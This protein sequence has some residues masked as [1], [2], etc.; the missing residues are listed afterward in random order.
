MGWKPTWLTGF[1]AR[2]APGFSASTVR[3]NLA[4]AESPSTNNH[5]KSATPSLLAR[6]CYHQS[7]YS[8]TENCLL[9]AAFMPPKDLRLSPFAVDGLKDAEIHAH[10]VKWATRRGPPPKP[11]KAFGKLQMIAI[12]KQK[13]FQFERDEPPPLHAVLT[14]WP[15]EK[16]EQMLL[17]EKLAEICGPVCLRTIPVTPSSEQSP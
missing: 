8:K 11:P 6:F 2:F 14:G 3:A 13:R 5:P 4:R 9:S 15:M 16:S 17:A 12:E 7:H 10:G 1:L